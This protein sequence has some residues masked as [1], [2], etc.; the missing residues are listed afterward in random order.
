MTDSERIANVAKLGYGEPEARFLTLVA[1]HGGYFVRREF[2]GHLGVKRG[3]RTEALVEKLLDRGHARRQVY[4]HNRQVFHL[5][6]RPLYAAVGDENSR[7][8]R[9]HQPQAVKA[10]LM[11]L[12]FVLAHPECRY[13]ATEV[14]RV[15]LFTG[16]YGI[17][18]ESLPAKLFGRSEASTS[19]RRYFVER[20][21][22]FV[23]PGK[24]DATFCYIDSGYETCSPF[25]TFLR[26]Y[27]ALFEAL[28]SF[29]LVYAGTTDARFGDAEAIFRR[30]LGK[31]RPWLPQLGDVDRL[32]AH[33]HDRALFEKRETAGFDRQRLDRLRDDFDSFSGDYFAEL[34]ES[35]KQH[36]DVILRSKLADVKVPC[37]RFTE[38]RLQHDY[39]MFGRVEVAS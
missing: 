16:G 2:D 30:V 35:W 17:A 8:R 32:V 31:G 27:A 25:V 13:Y 1:L 3:K 26:S 12:D 14:E 7:N 10:R 22:L 33:F 11:G 21:P 5:H 19:A 29:E 36:G 37:G 18:R 38:Y 39:E 15:G 24:D 9:D 4:E 23:R 6:F 34:F 20:F 28:P